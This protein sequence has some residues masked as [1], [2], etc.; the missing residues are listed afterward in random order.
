MGFRG[1]VVVIALAVAVLVTASARGQGFYQL[2]NPRIYRV[3]PPTDNPWDHGYGFGGLA[4]RPVPGDANGTILVSWERNAAALED[5]KRG[6]LA[7]VIIDFAS[8]PDAQGL[9]DAALVSQVFDW[10]WCENLDY[11]SDDRVLVVSRYDYEVSAPDRTPGTGVGRFVRDGGAITGFEM[12]HH[13]PI[14]RIGG[15]IR[16]GAFAGPREIAGVLY[17]TLGFVSFYTTVCGIFLVDIQSGK[18]IDA[19]PEAPN[20]DL[21]GNPFIGFAGNTGVTNL[22]SPI[23]QGTTKIAGFDVVGDIAFLLLLQTDSAGKPYLQLMQVNLVQKRLLA[24]ANVSQVL[25]P[26]RAGRFGGYTYGFDVSPLGNEKVRILIADGTERSNTSLAAIDGLSV[27]EGTDPVDPSAIFVPSNGNNSNG[28][29]TG[30]EQ[31]VVWVCPGVGVGL[32]ALAGIW[33]V[34]AVRRT[35]S[36]A[37]HSKESPRPL[38]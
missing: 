9:N 2:T 36:G 3:D 25:D 19:D 17:D 33:G 35:R 20:E 10:G 18:L 29:T 7:E 21:A 6:D 15:D 37:C 4:W 1:T 38:R 16:N 22:S 11:E 30:G 13:V 24:V 5:G 27:P 14:P 28:G 23:V 8:A 31:A 12:T 26:A 32:P 34:W